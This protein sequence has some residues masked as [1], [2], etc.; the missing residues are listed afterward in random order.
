MFDKNGV[1]NEGHWA[2]PSH[3]K[4]VQYQKNNPKKQDGGR[5][6][7]DRGETD[8]SWLDREYSMDLS[9]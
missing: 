4:T 6:L 7:E 5:P 1:E 2:C 9:G 3:P 8:D